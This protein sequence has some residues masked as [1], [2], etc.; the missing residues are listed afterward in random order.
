[1]QFENLLRLGAFDHPVALIT[2][3]RTLDWQQGHGHLK[4]RI[5]TRGFFVTK[6]R[7]HTDV[8]FVYNY[9]ESIDL[10]L[11]LEPQPGTP[12]H[13][14]YRQWEAG[15]VARRFYQPIQG[16]RSGHAFVTPTHPPIWL[17]N[18]PQL[19]GGGLV[20]MLHEHPVVV[21]VYAV[22]AYL[23]HVLDALGVQDPADQQT[24][25]NCILA[26][27]GKQWQG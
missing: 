24:I 14:L 27:L 6:F 7:P 20:V 22:G 26:E 21:D 11:I 12:E 19:G 10:N 16:L 2:H 25:A 4:I 5:V 18:T 13:E 8:A 3:Q 1:M 15:G 9:N 23:W 17:D